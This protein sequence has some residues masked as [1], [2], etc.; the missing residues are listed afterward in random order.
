VLVRN[1]GT[2]VGYGGAGPADVHLNAAPP[3][4]FGAADS[5]HVVEY[6]GALIAVSNTVQVGCED[7][8]TYHNDNLRTG[9]NPKETVLT[10][11][12]VQKPGGFGWLATAH[13]DDAN[14]QID[15]QPLVVA[16]QHI[17]G[18]GSRTVVYVATENDSVYAFDSFTGAKLKKVHLGAPVPRPLNCENN[19]DVVGVNS[20]PTID[21]KAGVLYVVA[22]VLH[23]TTP[24]HE[25]HMLDLAT[26][27]DKVPPRTIGA[28]NTLVDGSTYTFDS[29]VQRQR[30]ALLQANGNVYAGFAS[31]CDAKAA[32]SRGWVLGWGQSILTPLANTP[33]LAKTVATSTYDCYVFPPWTSDHPCYLASVWMSGFGIAADAAGNLFF[34]TGNTGMTKP[35]GGVSL[36]DSVND[37][38][39][40]MVKM[41]PDLSGILDFFTPSNVSALDQIDQDYGSG[42]ALL[43]PDQPGPT[44]R[45]AVAAGKEGLLYIVNR[46]TGAMGG[47]KTPNVAAHVD[48]GGDCHCGPSYYKGVDGVGRVVTS[49]GPNLLQW[50]VDTSASPALAQEAS[51]PFASGQDGGGFTSIS[52]NGTTAN[53]AIVWAVGRP[54]SKNDVRVTLYAFDAAQSGGA[55]TPLWHDF[56][57]DWP[58]IGGNA[59]IVPTVANGRV[60]VASNKQVQIFGLLHPTKAVKRKLERIAEAV[61]AAK[62]VIPDV[63]PMHWGVIRAADG[64]V[65][66]LE[67]RE[68]RTIKVDLTNIMPVATSDFGAIGRSL[69]VAGPLRDGVVKATAAWRVKGPAFYGDD[70][71][72]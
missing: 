69:A 26:L 35:S 25:L 15:G 47:F 37:V 58:N 24:A 33:L 54:M 71:E 56:A 22:Y 55:L 53:T 61:P 31:Y 23:G 72:E 51:T 48:I 29:S 14:D 34:T 70:R 41:A 62:S 64:G 36:Y 52:S 27:Q 7:V 20:T 3:N 44:P 8:L 12:D 63:G 9:W 38:A 42:G 16:D 11:A 65:I 59:N 66:A 21:R 45:L 49:G 18:V 2:I 28:T 60:Y 40:T 10:P 1:A 17:D 43:L 67:L 32:N 46:D 4:A 5:A 50:K 57:G 39:D 6:I 68:G 13:L 19:G 30:A